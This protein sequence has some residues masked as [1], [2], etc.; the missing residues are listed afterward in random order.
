MQKIIL[1]LL[2]LM[3]TLLNAG[4]S[5]SKIDS[6]HNADWSLAN[7]ENKAVIDHDKFQDILDEYL[8]TDDED[9][10]NLFDYDRVTDEDKAK[11]DLYLSE[12]AALDPS[13]YNSNEQLAYWINLYNAL[14]VQLILDRDPTFSI[15]TAG[16]G[17]LP[18]GP[19]DDKVVAVNGKK[20]TLNNIEHD[21]L[22]PLWQDHRIHF[23]V[24]CASVGCPNLQDSVF[25]SDNV[26][27]LLD[28]GA[29]DY[30]GH[31]RGLEFRKG[32]LYLSKIFS[33]YKED[34]GET[35]QQML[36]VLSQYLD[37]DLADKVANYQ[38]K[39]KYHYDWS[40]NKV[41]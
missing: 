30:L 4:D 31:P 37:E 32:K 28:E 34:F 16:K 17:I 6:E 13:T 12:L 38:G 36:E 35:D 29:I 33:W 23:A 11:L 9:D 10:I 15:L 39:I 19:W 8:V 25:T 20:L 21:I 14:T 27:D 22:R 1:L 7:E 2:I 24:N 40:L 3:T 18:N 26:G 41:K 5:Q